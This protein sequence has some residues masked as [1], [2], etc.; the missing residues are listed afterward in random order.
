[1]CPCSNNCYPEFDFLTNYLLENLRESADMIFFYQT[2]NNIK[3]AF[4][5]FLLCIWSCLCQWRMNESSRNFIMVVTSFRFKLYVLGVKFNN[6]THLII[7]HRIIVKYCIFT[8]LIATKL[9][10]SIK[11]HIATSLTMLK[12]T[13]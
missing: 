13:I 5:F 6:W 3:I 9:V 2:R 1:M 4:W 8:L 7:F 12:C 10:H 11:W